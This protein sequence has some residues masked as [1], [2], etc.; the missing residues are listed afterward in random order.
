MII[1]SQE[2]GISLPLFAQLG[3]R[4]LAIIYERKDNRLFSETY[5]SSERAQRNPICPVAQQNERESRLP[6]PRR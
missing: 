2:Y 5:Y 3:K 4:T 1:L 6:L